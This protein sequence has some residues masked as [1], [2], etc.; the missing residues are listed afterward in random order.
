[1]GTAHRRSGFDS[2][3]RLPAIYLAGLIGAI[4][5]AKIVYMLA[6]GWMLW[7]NYAEQPKLVWQEWFT[8]KTVTGALLGGY[9]S[10]ELTKKWLKYPRATGDLFAVLAPLGLGLGRVGCWAQG[11]C[12]GITKN[13]GWWTITD[14]HGTHR[15]PSVQIELLFNI[16]LFAFALVCWR[17]HLFEGQLFH[18]YLIAYGLFR[19]G[20]EFLRATPTIVGPISGYQFAALCI[21]ALGAVRYRQRERGNSMNSQLTTPV[22]EHG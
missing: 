1:M 12:L 19:F 10:V 18:I 14:V 17:R 5:G 7:P 4:L 20:H 11:C 8:G 22:T 15:W 13:A 16:T 6:E 9:L 21:L 2:D 3:R